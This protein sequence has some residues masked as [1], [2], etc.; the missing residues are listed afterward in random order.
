MEIK[1]IKYVGPVFD[2]SGYAQAARGY[3]LAL[4]R[5][6]IPITINSVSFE[7]GMSDFGEVGNIL[8]KLVNRNIE[9]NIVIIHLTVEHYEKFCEPGK[10][11]IGYSVWET[12]KIHD[13]W[14]K[15]LNQSVSA[16]MTASDF[17]V[18]VYKNSGVEIPVLNVP[19][20]IDMEEYRG[21]KEYTIKG[22]D[23][24]AYKFYAILQ[25]FERKHPLGLV[26]AYWYAF[27]NDE[28]VALVLKTYRAG[29]SEEQSNIIKKT[30]QMCRESMPMDKYP[31]IY[32]ITKMLDRDEVLGLHKFCDCLTHVDRG[33]GFGLVPFEA[34]ACGNPVIVTGWGGVTEYANKDNSYLID[35]TLTPVYGMPWSP[36]YRGDQLWAE[37]DIYHASRTM[38]HV[39]NNREEASNRGKLLQRNIEEN[40]GWDD[41]GNKM[42]EAI[43]SL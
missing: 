32:L 9:Y 15:W 3:I 6:G 42:I 27:Q 40:F 38:Q 7:E 14:V 20:G 41:V 4:H 21:I 1:G 5:L 23:P 37:P 8:S 29:F 34:G 33:E 36:F 26:R 25:F 13:Q 12:S 39:Y 43:K 2:A 28:N 22:I 17:L 30:L 35:Y 11:N 19:H 10:V 18:D 31:P 24:E 16:V